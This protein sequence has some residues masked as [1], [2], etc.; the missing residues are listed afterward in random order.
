MTIEVQ[1]ARKHAL[2]VQEKAR[3]Q[4]YIAEDEFSKREKEIERLWHR[5]V[6]RV[7]REFENL[8]KR[9]DDREHEINADSSNLESVRPSSNPDLFDE[10]AWGV[11][12]PVIPVSIAEEIARMAI[13][14]AESRIV[15]R[16]REYV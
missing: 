5:R 1:D 15:E 13:A 6:E 8:K 11:M 7:K 2:N 4:H 12:E 10:P 3:I 16:M 9:W 14:D